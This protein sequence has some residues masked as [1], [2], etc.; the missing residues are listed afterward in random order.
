[1]QPDFNPGDKLLIN[2]LAYTFSAPKKGDI[3]AFYDQVQRGKILLK[4]I[5]TERDGSYFVVGINKSDSRDSRDIGPITRKQII[6]KF[7]MSY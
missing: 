4:R 6:G 2:R 3:V 1:M 5:E 7:L